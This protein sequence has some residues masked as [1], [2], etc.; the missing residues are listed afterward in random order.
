MNL[1]GI[2]VALAHE[3]V[4]RLVARQHPSAG[5]VFVHL[6]LDSLSAA[7]LVELA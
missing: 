2:D 4:Q 6:L 1:V 3:A 7:G 5:V